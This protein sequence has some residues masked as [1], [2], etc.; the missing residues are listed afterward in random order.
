M[1]IPQNP[2]V[3]L[4]LKTCETKTAI[5]YS[6]RKSETS[7]NEFYFD[8]VRND[9]FGKK[10]LRLIKFFQE[11]F[12]ILQQYDLKVFSENSFPI[13]LELP[14]VPAQWQVSLFQ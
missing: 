6:K 3:S 7:Q 8:G 2:S 13:V 4:T 14:Q 1:Q 10:A 11:D 9:S 12:Q 5:S